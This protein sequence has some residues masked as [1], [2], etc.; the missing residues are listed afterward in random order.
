MTT[1]KMI[2]TNNWKKYGT[3]KSHTCIQDEMQ[4]NVPVAGMCR[5][6]MI[7]HFSFENQLAVDIPEREHWLDDDHHPWHLIPPSSQT[8][9]TDGS[10]GVLGTGAGICFNGLTSDLPL[11]HYTSVFQAKTHA[12]MQC[13][14]ALKRLRFLRRTYLYLFRWSGCFDGNTILVPSLRLRIGP[15]CEAGL[16]A[17]MRRERVSPQIRKKE[18]TSIIH[19]LRSG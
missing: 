10:G 13:A 15:A 18:R 4:Q 17:G 6:Y 14:L 8:V 12:I 2:S 5:D 7:P 1:Y 11:G 16:C 3:S 19:I 9:Y